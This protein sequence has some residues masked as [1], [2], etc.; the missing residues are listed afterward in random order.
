MG[1]GDEAKSVAFIFIIFFILLYAELL[2]AADE[3]DK[4]GGDAEKGKNGQKPGG[5]AEEP[6]E[7]VTDGESNSD[8][9]RKHKPERAE[10]GQLAVIDAARSSA[11]HAAI[12]MPFS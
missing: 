9:G 3:A 7:E 1:G 10:S 6:V 2:K 5:S 4:P 12:F 8:G 11:G